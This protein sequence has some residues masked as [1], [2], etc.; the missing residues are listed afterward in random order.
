MHQWRSASTQTRAKVLN[1]C[2]K[3]FNQVVGAFISRCHDYLLHWLRLEKRIREHNYHCRQVFWGK[4]L[5]FTCHLPRWWIF[6]FQR[7][8]E[9]WHHNGVSVGWKSLFRMSSL[10]PPLPPT[11]TS[12]QEC[13]QPPRCLMPVNMA[14]LLSVCSPLL[15]L[16]FHALLDKFIKRKK[17]KFKTE[18]ERIA[19]RRVGLNNSAFMSDTGFVFKRTRD[20]AHLPFVLTFMSRANLRASA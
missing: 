18:R 9:T 7:Q 8:F 10:T 14:A 12:H 13:H 1:E 16:L 5:S 2:I 17:K 11:R 15:S 19:A 20:L 6:C 4:S 3:M